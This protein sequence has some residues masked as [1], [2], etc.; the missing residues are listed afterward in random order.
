[1][2]IAKNIETAV[3]NK[4]ITLLIQ[5]QWKVTYQYDGMDAG[6]DYNSLTLKKETEE[7]NF[8]WTNWYEGEIRC[9]PDRLKEIEKLLGYE[10]KTLEVIDNRAPGTPKK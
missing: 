3:W 5:N 9:T 7:I 6:I 1:M 10:F 2:V 8:E 4:A